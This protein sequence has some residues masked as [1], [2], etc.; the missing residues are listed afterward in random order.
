MKYNATHFRANLFKIL[1]QII[2]TGVPIEIER[3]GQKVKIVPV[4][5]REKLAN[6]KS[7]PGTIIG[8]P[9]DL[10]HVDWSIYWKYDDDIS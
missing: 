3:K 7:H 1:D 8:N 6:L 4:K 2:E 10:V 9:E 5:K